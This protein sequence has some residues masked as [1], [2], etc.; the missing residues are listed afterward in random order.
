MLYMYVFALLDTF[1]SNVKNKR[2]TLNYLMNS[3]SCIF[4][5]LGLFGAP[6]GAILGLVARS[7]DIS[8]QFPRIAF[9]IPGELRVV[10]QTIMEGFL[11]AGNNIQKNIYRKI[12]RTNYI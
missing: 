8:I 7:F 12:Y 3:I 1:S 5:L 6:Y 2:K 10:R 9:G 4:S 11:E